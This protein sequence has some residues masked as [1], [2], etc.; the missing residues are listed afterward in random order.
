MQQERGKRKSVWKL[1]KVSDIPVTAEV[2]Q[3]RERWEG[4][5]VWCLMEWGQWRRGKVQQVLNDGVIV[6]RVYQRGTSGF[7]VGMLPEGA[8]IL[9]RLVEQ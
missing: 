8:D 1:V 2:E 6:I 5:Q 4:K 3:A 9:L 7:L